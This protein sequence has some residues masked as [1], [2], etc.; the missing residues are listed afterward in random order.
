MERK[1][2]EL[3][4]S[5]GLL[6]LGAYLRAQGIE[7]ALTDLTFARDARPVTTR[8]RSFLP[9]VVGVH[10]KTLT[11]GR[12]VD[13]AARARAE[14]AFA[15]AGRADAA[16]RSEEYLD[17]GFDAVVPGE[18]EGAL[19]DLARKIHRGEDPAG[20]AGLLL[21]RGGRLV[22][23]PHRPFFRDLDALPLPAW[24]LVDMEDTSD[25]GSERPAS[26]APQS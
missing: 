12:A 23:G 1:F 5:L 16:T 7:V 26:D 10:T 21:R 15:V 8:L 20:I 11:Y 3:Y 17:A 22:R 6:N 24:D 13:V 18:G 25:A 14:G 9:D 2:V 19:V 4:P